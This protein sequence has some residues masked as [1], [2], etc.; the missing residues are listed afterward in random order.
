M[1]IGPLVRRCYRLAFIHHP[2]LPATPSRHPPDHSPISSGCPPRPL[3]RGAHLRTLITRPQWPAGGRGHPPA[4][5][6]F[7]RPPAHGHQAAAVTHRG[8]S[9]PSATRTCR[10]RIHPSFT[11]I[12]YPPRPCFIFNLLL[13]PVHNLTYH[14]L[15]TGP[16][17]MK[18]KKKQS[19]K[20]IR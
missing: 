19:K 15:G 17:Q 5:A 9:I 16:V 6:R 11:T 7:L 14:L 10:P 18:K 3:G 12:A 13:I 8:R 2:L 20:W 1:S 4:A